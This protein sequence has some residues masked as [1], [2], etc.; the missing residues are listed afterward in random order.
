MNLEI[1]TD[2]QLEKMDANAQ[3]VIRALCAWSNRNMSAKKRAE[4]VQDIR[5]KQDAIL[6]DQMKRSG[7]VA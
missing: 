7:V 3:R 4:C 5:V 6:T 2:A 1:K